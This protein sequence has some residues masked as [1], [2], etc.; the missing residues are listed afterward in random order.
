[1]YGTIISLDYVDHKFKIITKID[2]FKG[3]MD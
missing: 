3:Y 2:L 1:M